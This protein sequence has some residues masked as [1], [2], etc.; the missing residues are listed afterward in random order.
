MH[1]RNA[2]TRLM[3]E[4]GYGEG[5]V[6]AHGEADAFVATRNLP[7]AVGDVEWYEPTGRGAEAAIAARLSEW[8]RRR[9]RTE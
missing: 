2:P 3:E 6:Y 7:E 5:Y 9:A 8:R 1:L 4:L